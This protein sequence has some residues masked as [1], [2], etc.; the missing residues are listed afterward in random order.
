LLAIRVSQTGAQW[1]ATQVWQ[2]QELFSYLSSPIKQDGLLYGMSFRNKGQYFCVDLQTGQIQWR[3]EG[4]QGESAAVL[5]SGNELFI[6]TVDG[7]LIV[8]R[9]SREKF[10]IVKRYKVADSATWAHPVLF[11]RHLL[12][13]DAN[14]LLLWSLS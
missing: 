4:R 11:D 1:E 13:K 8:A 14:S 6:Q 9:T 5:R 2:R 7:E 3:T 10:D 12:V